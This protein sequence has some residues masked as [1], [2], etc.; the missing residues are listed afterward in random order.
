MVAANGWLSPGA[1]T[2]STVIQSICFHAASKTWMVISASLGPAML[3]A[4]L[5]VN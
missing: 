4:P 1:F 3:T 5:M 2:S